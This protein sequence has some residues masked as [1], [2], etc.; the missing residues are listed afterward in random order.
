[1]TF[2]ELTQQQMAQLIDGNKLLDGVCEIVGSIPDWNCE[3]TCIN[4][5][6]DLGPHHLCSDCLESLDQRDENEP[7]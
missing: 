2:H 1:M 3:E 4:C 5:G 6:N 7:K